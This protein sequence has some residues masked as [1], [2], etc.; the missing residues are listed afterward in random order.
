M[1]TQSKHLAS[2]KASKRNLEEKKWN[3][4]NK[5]IFRNSPGV[6]KKNNNKKKTK[7]L[8]SGGNNLNSG[9]TQFPETY[10]IKFKKRRKKLMETKK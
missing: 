7:N 1:M 4:F 10:N 2:T 8:N 6:S 5:K 9:E 3:L